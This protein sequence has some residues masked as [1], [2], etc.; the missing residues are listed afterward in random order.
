MNNMPQRF[1][2]TSKEP[3]RYL[4]ITNN[5]ASEE[6]SILYVDLNY[7]TPDSTESLQSKVEE[8]KAFVKCP[9]TILNQTR[10]IA[11]T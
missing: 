4:D 1:V 8:V 6:K 10:R 11:G 7:L 2:Y 9:Y 3:I 5:S